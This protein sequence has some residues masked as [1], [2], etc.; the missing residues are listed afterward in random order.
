MPAS[1]P[2]AN[3]AP[4]TG[5][6]RAELAAARAA[7]AEAQAR[8]TYYQQ[9]FEQQHRAVLI[10]G[11]GCYTDCNGTALRLL[12][13]SRRDQLLGQPVGSFSM[14]VQPDGRPTP[15]RIAEVLDQVRRLGW[16]RF[17]W[18][19]R[20]HTGEE[21]WEDVVVT[22][23]REAG[24]ELFHVSWEDTSDRP[25]R[26]GSSYESENRLQLALA[27]T[28]SGVWISHLTA[29]YTYCDQRA[30]ALLG[31]AE[32]ICPHEAL[33]PLLHPDDLPRLR[34]AFRQARRERQP[35]DVEFRVQHPT[36]G[37]RYLMAMGQ[38]Q[39]DAQQRPVR[40][41]GLL[42]DITDRQRTRLELIRKSELL[43]QMLRH[44]PLIL[45]RFD[46][47]GRIL[48]LVGAGLRH[49]HTTDNEG[50]GRQAGYLMQDMQE[51]IAQVLTGQHVRFVA[52]GQV[53][54]QPVYLQC[55]GFFDESQQCGV[56]FSINATESELSKE[57]LRTE[58]EFS[59][60]LLNHSLDAIAACDQHGS[61]TA[62]N[63]IMERLSGVPASTMLGQ[64]LPEFPVFAGDTAQ[65]AALRSILSGQ[66]TPHYNVPFHCHNQDCEANLLPLPMPEGSAY[67]VLVV[68]RDVTQRNQLAAEATRL[69]LR[70]QQEIL[71][72]VLEAQEAERRRIAEGLH[73]GVGQLLYAAKLSLPAGPEV[74]A[75]RAVLEE[76][77]RATRT[78]SFELTPGVLADFGLKT[79][80][81]ELFKRIPH[82]HLPVQLHILNLPP[83]LPAPVEMAAY[84][85]VQELLNN[86]L[87]HARATTALVRVAYRNQALHLAVHDNGVGFEPATGPQPGLGLPSIRNRVE[88]LQGTLQL[89]SRPGQGTTVQITIPDTPAPEG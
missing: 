25:P 3:P 57:R 21:F 23:I 73:N 36:E 22:C 42:R 26:A 78:I 2:F 45:G 32:A 5:L 89:T 71:S 27:A 54:G 30:R 28:H 16:G 82:Q 83:R 52:R 37:L 70:R 4:D 72:A 7:L 10:I 34:A 9:L 35:F 68:I 40:I 49:L 15:A 74:Q 63:H 87:K 33:L 44:L 59:E 62:W 6:L 41:T 64:Q 88:L 13:L 17:A 66:N 69:Q 46:R 12:G 53:Q 51:P 81:E 1:S 11:N 14:P 60:R 79:A 48:E 43:E 38:V 75:T 61:V 86:M 55:F 58:K 8:A 65:G 67:G 31:A 80:L 84:R 19:G 76:A 29:G 47:Q 20:R 85:I 18:L 24:Q 77:I 39:F 56:I 50:V